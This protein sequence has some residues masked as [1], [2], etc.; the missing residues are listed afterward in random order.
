MTNKNYTDAEFIEAV[1]TSFSI[2]EVLRKIGVVARGGNYRIA[3]RGIQRLNLNTDHFTGC[4]HMKGKTHNRS[5]KTPLDQLLVENCQCG[6]TSHKLK[7]RLIKEGFFERKCYNC[8]RTEWLSNPIP[9]ELEHKNGDNLDNR[10]ENL[11]LLCPNC[12]ALTD[13]YRG[14]NKKGDKNNF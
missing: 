1:K 8:E 2:A 14:K 13:T 5:K 12:H 10:I 11:T 6:V 7:L 3:R 9:L 4:G